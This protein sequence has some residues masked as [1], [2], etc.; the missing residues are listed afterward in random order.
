MVIDFKRFLYYV[1]LVLELTKKELKIR[2]KSSVLGYLWSVLNPLLLAFVFF[3]AFKLV[4]KV[5]VEDYVVFL[6]SGLFAWQWIA[7][8]MQTSTVVLISNGSLIKKTVFPRALLPLSLVLN[9]AFH[10]IV[11]IPIIILFLIIYHKVG[12]MNFNWLYGIPI[13]IILT[14]NI[15][16]GF[17]LIISSINVF[18][19][20]LERIIGLLIQ[21]LFYLTP[22]IY[23][24]QMIP[25]SLR[26]S[27][28]L[29]PFSPLIISYR[30]LFLYGTF[31][32]ID[33]LVALAY[34]LVILGIGNL[35][36]IKLKNKFAEVI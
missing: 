36:F 15:T 10:F 8:S 32:W 22:I 20:D 17:T 21:L 28:N 23:S 16:Y 27:L 33:C 25:K 7:N 4:M 3:T 6:I 12:A 19:R 9:D 34:G 30:D 18:F 26:W 5:R 31:D 29:N 1:D 11:S 14:F 35:V 13:L 2:Y 24:E